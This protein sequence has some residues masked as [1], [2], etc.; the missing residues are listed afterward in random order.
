MESRGKSQYVGAQ[1]KTNAG[2][3]RSGLRWAL[4]R[5]MACGAFLA[6]VWAPSLALGQLSQQNNEGLEIIPL[7][8]T[9]NVTNTAPLFVYIQGLLPRGSNS[10]QPR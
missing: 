4:V 6:G 1:G 9:N 10:Y 2:N 7:T 3:R 5:T 8:I